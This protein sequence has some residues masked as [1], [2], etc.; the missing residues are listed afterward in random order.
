MWAGIGEDCRPRTTWR[1]LTLTGS[2]ALP[3]LRLT[4]GIATPTRRYHGRML[5]HPSLPA[6]ATPDMKRCL[7]T[8]RFGT[9]AGPPP[10]VHG[11][12]WG[13]LSPWPQ[14]CN[15]AVSCHL[16]LQ[17]GLHE[18]LAQFLPYAVF[19][20]H[21]LL[22]YMLIWICHHLFEYRLF[23]RLFCCC[24]TAVAAVSPLRLLLC[25][26]LSCLFFYCAVTFAAPVAALL[27]PCCLAAA[28]AAVAFAAVAGVVAL[29]LPLCFC[30]FFLQFCCCFCC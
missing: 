8:R 29:F 30:F 13:L 9:V 28:L 18:F 23:L 24:L 15:D 5:I 21:L 25:C 12:P 10:P 11:T 19:W 26:C 6:W 22:I 3:P 2:P 16:S 14:Q 7:H 20:F 1:P 4:G 17:Y 27:L